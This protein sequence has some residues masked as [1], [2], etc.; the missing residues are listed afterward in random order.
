MFF[1]SR[2]RRCSCGFTLIELLVVISIIAL[3]IAVLLP[4]LSSA[5]SAARSV[6]CLSLHRQ[7][8]IAMTLYADD[9]DGF[10]PYAKF[11]PSANPANP[12]DTNNVFG[13]SGPNMLHWV[14]YIS[15]Y[16]GQ[17]AN[18]IDNPNPVPLDAAPALSACPEWGEYG[19]E[20]TS[21][22]LGFGMN[23]YMLRQHNNPDP[24][25]HIFNRIRL[26]QIMPHSKHILVGDSCDWHLF[27]DQWSPPSPSFQPSSAGPCPYV[28]GDPTRHSKGKTANYLFADG[29][30]SS[31]DEE[32]AVDLLR[33]VDRY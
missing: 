22:R 29:S 24:T 15:E 7:I 1:P 6:Y 12:T 32:A 4:A 10:L 3:L 19:I 17:K 21:A 5:R 31:L 16:M 25:N 28:S 18:T 2:I 9:H 26:S 14:E 8:G 33:L 11:N 20:P 23:I 13:G 30:A 27:I